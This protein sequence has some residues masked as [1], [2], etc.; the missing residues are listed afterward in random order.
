[1]LDSSQ[2]AIGFCRGKSRKIFDMDRMLILS[3]VQCLQIVGEAAGKV[4]GA[5]R[6]KWSE[7]PWPILVGL[8]NRLVH[9]YF[10][11]NLDIVWNTVQNDLPPL[12]AALEKI[13]DKDS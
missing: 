8:R 6:A 1:M 12:V 4:S 3:V 10:D 11:I 13:L 7:I 5:S 9:A 2:E